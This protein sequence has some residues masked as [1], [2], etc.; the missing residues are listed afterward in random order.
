MVEFIS[1]EKGEEA[2][3]NQVKDAEEHQEQFQKDV[4]NTL[5][6]HDKAYRDEYNR[7]HPKT[8]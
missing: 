6:L 2:I 7:K 1:P 8:S 4:H 5:M 3:K